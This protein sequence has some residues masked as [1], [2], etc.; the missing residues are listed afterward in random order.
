M[1]MVFYPLKDVTLRGICDAFI[2][3]DY[4]KLK[5]GLK[6]MSAEAFAASKTS[7][8][9]SGT[10]LLKTSDADTSLIKTMSDLNSGACLGA[11]VLLTLLSN[12]R[13]SG[14]L[15]VDAFLNADARTSVSGVVVGVALGGSIG[16]SFIILDLGDMA[17]PI[18][19]KGDVTA[20]K[21][22]EASSL[23]SG[24]GITATLSPTL[25]VPSLF[26]S[27]KISMGG[28]VSG[29]TKRFRNLGDLLGTTLADL[30]GWNLGTYFY[31][32]V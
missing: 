18:T 12:A 7:I 11:D 4:S 25:K 23:P 20:Q 13:F 15:A 31:L 3:R 27:V 24:M 14:G 2:V 29:T 19:I 1:Q 22:L 6:I 32:E 26:S 16:N 10:L 30:R 21:T 9:A 17:V 5:T 8:I 28:S